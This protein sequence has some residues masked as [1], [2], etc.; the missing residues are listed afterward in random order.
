MLIPVPITADERQLGLRFHVRAENVPDPVPAPRCIV[1]KSLLDPH[2]RRKAVTCSFCGRVQWFRV[3]HPNSKK[4][5]YLG[6][7]A[8]LLCVMITPANLRAQNLGSNS[9][10]VVNRQGIPL[11]GVN[12]AICQPAATTAA[13]VTNNIAVLTMAS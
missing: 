1:C 4:G 2:Y 6:F 9:S 3:H 8:I 5:G 12:I 10:P 13:S 11:G 7:L